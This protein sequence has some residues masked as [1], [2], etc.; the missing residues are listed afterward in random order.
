MYKVYILHGWTYSIEKWRPFLDLL[1]KNGTEYEMLKIPGLTAP[2][3]DVWTLDDYVSWLKPVV[4][5]QGSVVL[6]GHSNGGRIAAAFTAKYPE[7][8][9]RL[10][11]IDCAGIIQ[12]DFKTLLRKTVFATAAKIGG[13]VT[14][15]DSIRNLFYKAVGEQDYNKASPILKK[16]ML[17]LISQDLEPIFSKIS[18]P[19]LIIWGNND[20]VTPVSDGGKIHKFVSGSKFKII[21]TAKH[22]PQFTNPDEVFEIIKQN[23]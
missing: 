20:K 21:E 16:T 3:S 1:E 8:I 12:R 6:L 11:L 19:T 22:S 9:S 5:G 2:L 4:S 23:L 13:K 15:S 10:I 18:D 14:K 17:N 7:M